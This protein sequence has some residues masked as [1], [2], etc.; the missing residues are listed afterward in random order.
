MQRFGCWEPNKD[1]KKSIIFHPCLPQCPGVYV[2]LMSLQ[3]LWNKQK[4]KEEE[5]H[6]T[7]LVC[8]CGW[9]PPIQTFWPWSRL[10][11]FWRNKKKCLFLCFVD[12][13]STGMLIS[14]ERRQANKRSQIYSSSRWTVA[15]SASVCSFNTCWAPIAVVYGKPDKTKEGVC[16]QMAYFEKAP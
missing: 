5:V 14:W 10:I 15:C 1:L 16:M 7:C 8:F 2:I 13:N 6:N 12:F 11:P 4:K 3:F 9:Y